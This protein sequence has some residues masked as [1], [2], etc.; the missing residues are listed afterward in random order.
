MYLKEFGMTKHQIPKNMFVHFIEFR[1]VV[2]SLIFGLEFIM[3]TNELVI[4][5]M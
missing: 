5:F 3:I 2:I 1:E 4:V